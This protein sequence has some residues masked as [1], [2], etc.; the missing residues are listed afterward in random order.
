MNQHDMIAIVGVIAV[1]VFVLGARFVAAVLLLAV[2]VIAALR[3]MPAAQSEP[4]KLVNGTYSM[5]MMTEFKSTGDIIIVGDNKGGPMVTIHADGRVDMRPDVEAR[6]A[7]RIF[8]QAIGAT[9]PKCK[10]QP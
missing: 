9:I 6:E 7:A 10:V 5:S 8:W 1:C 4:L 3:Y 2:L